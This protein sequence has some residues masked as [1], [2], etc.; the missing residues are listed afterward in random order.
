[1]AHIPVN[2]PLRP[3]YRV[4]AAL[5]GAYVLLFGIIGVARTAGDDLFARDDVW[6]LGLR[7][8]LAFAIASVIFGAV[9]LG[10]NV[11][12][13]YLAHLVTLGGSLVFM[14]GGLLMMTL[15]QTS[16]NFLNFSMSTVIVSLTFSLLLL[17]AGL[18]NKVGTAEEAER[19]D[20]FRHNPVP[21][22]ARRPASGPAG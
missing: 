14:V 1:M 8:N 13:G 11:V 21:V 12:G 15:L 5:V 22:P 3:L 20:A 9:V 2:H 19:E 6:V 7:T 17:A 4:L 10:A 18:Y 16:G